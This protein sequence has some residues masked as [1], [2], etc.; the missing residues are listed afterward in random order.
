MNG[1]IERWRQELAAQAGL[2][3]DIRRELEAHLQDCI[4]GFQQLGLGETEAF[5]LACQRIG[6]PR[7]LNTEFTKAM[8]PTSH[9]N[10]PLAITAWTLFIVS[11]ALP[12][13]ASMFGWQC[14]MLQSIF[15]PGTL[16][17]NRLSV[18]Y[19]FLTLANLLMLASPL[20]LL[21]F[22]RSLRQLQWL[23]YLTLAAAVLVWAFVLQLLFHQDNGLKAGCFVWAIS[24]ALL[25]FSVL[26]QLNA[27]RKEAAHKHA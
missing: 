21:R 2:T 18:H 24:F 23:H 27:A 11:F 5:Q 12:S 3:A 19:E 15:W 22:S 8:N 9:W 1:A 26:S 17:G 16:Q 4:A 10:R 7:Q 14:A 6:K 20:L 25:Y 13:Y